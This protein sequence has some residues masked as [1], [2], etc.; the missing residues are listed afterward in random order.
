[1]ITKEDFAYFQKNKKDAVLIQHQLTCL[2]NKE[3]PFSIQKPAT[4]GHGIHAFPL[5]QQKHYRSFF[6]QHG[7]QI[8][9][10]KFV[11]ASGLASRM[12]Y[13][14]R[15]FLLNF[16]PDQDDFEAYLTDEVNQEF[17][18]FV[19]HIEDFPFYDLIK[20]QIEKEDRKF[21]TD[22]AFI[23]QFIQIL[24]DDAVLG[25]EGKAKALLPLFS[26]SKAAHDSAFELQ[27]KEA[28]QLFSRRTKTKI[29][30]TIDAD[31]LSH[32]IALENKLSEKIAKVDCER[33]QIEY[34]FQDPKTDSVVL[35]SKDRLLRDDDNNLIFRKS[36]HGALFNN[37]KR[38]D[39]DLMFI[40]SIDSVWP[41]DQQSMVIQKAMG[42][43]YLERFDQ[44]K[45]L[46]EQ[47]QEAIA[48]GIDETTAF[49]QN[50]FHIDFSSKLNGLNLDEQIQRLMDFL[51]RPLRVCGMITNEGK[52]GGGPFWIEQNGEIAL[53]IVESSELQ[54]A[55]GALHDVLFFNPVNMVCGLKDFKGD[56]WEL[57]H[58]KDSGRSIISEKT[59]MGKP[60]RTFELPG[61]WNGSMGYWNSIFVEIPTATFR[62]LKTINDCLEQKKE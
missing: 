43:L 24:L 41:M 28:L 29:H 51:N 36:G 11:P 20:N 10:M 57:E 59:Q 26:N 40:K 37:I 34:S 13:F 12:F 39:T 22:A 52:P 48:T 9:T 46:L 45:N 33:L 7:S 62:S 32:F 31:Q 54:A 5:E 14:L 25:M 44:I 23:H 58:Y 50:C 56:S 3:I 18:Y 53:Q 2:K 4:L 15:D 6:D 42:G 21:T 1:M 35:L 8:N 17:R 61:L 19:Q 16:D 30:F 55:Q 27:I 38:F 60:I 47:L 49:I